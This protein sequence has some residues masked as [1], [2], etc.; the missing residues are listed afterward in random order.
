M[1]IS[2]IAAVNPAAN[3]TAMT[4]LD[5]ASGNSATAGTSGTDAGNMF[6]RMLDGLGNVQNNA[7]A[8]AKQ[9]ATGSLQDVQN[10]TIAATQAS[11]AT[12]LTVAVRNR[13]V[14]AFNEIMRMQ[15]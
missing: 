1:S 13:A 10:Y 4:P 14:D 12:D 5:A 2:P 7:D 15:I 9:A 11:L 6:T 8:L 3:L